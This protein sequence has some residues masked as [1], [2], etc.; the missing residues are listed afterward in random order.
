MVDKRYG[1]LRVQAS[2]CDPPEV[3]NRDAVPKDDRNGRKSRRSSSVP[4]RR[5][6]LLT[7]SKDDILL[8]PR[9]I[10]EAKMTAK[11]FERTKKWRDMAVIARPNGIIGYQFPITKKVNLSS[12]VG[13][14]L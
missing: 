10:D 5:K 12:V 2:N 14:S 4:A 3:R 1:F 13:D 9:K 11:E 6:K 7:K 8:Q